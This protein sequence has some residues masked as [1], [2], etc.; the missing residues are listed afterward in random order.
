MGVH[1]LLQ[2]ELYFFTLFFM[3]NTNKLY[4]L[5]NCSVLREFIL[6]VFSASKII[7]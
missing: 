1:G 7:H 4:C 5:Q 3:K 6:S 2:G